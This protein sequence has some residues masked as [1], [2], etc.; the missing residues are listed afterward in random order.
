MVF[1]RRPQWL[2]QVLLALLTFLSVLQTTIAASASTPEDLT[3]LETASNKSLLWGPYRPN[4]YFGIRPR[5]PKSLLLGLM[6]ARVDEYAGVQE[7]F[8]HTCE[9]HNSIHGYGWDTYDTRRGG[10]QTI[11]DEGNGIDLK[12]K[13]VKIPNAG[14]DGGHWGVRVSGTPRPGFPSDVKTNILFYAALE[15][16]GR[17][18]PVGD[19]VEEEKGWRGDVVIEGEAGGLGSF[20]IK[21]MGD[22]M[23]SSN[24]H[25]EHGHPSGETRRLDRTFLKSFQLP[26]EALWQNLPILFAHL[27]S[28]IDKLMEEYGK[29]NLPPPEQLFVI[30]NEGGPGNMHLVQKVFE[31]AFEFDVLFSSGSAPEP[32]TSEQLTDGIKANKKEFE[33]RFKSVLKPQ[34]P[35]DKPKYQQF[36]ESL[37]SNLMGGIGYFYGDSKVDR[38]GADEYLEENEEFWTETEEARGKNEVSTEGP[39][40]LFTSIPSRPF[41]PRGFLWDEGF[42]LM[43]IIDWDTDLTLDIIKSWFSLIDDDGWIAREQILGPEARSKVP[44][45]FQVQYPHYANPPTLFITLQAFVDKLRKGSSDSSSIYLSNP[46]AATKYL[47]DLY[48]LLKRHYAWFRRT[49]AGD[50]KSYDREAFSTKEGYRWRGRTPAHILTSGLDDYPR[51]QPPHPG[52]LHVD[53]L[54]WVGTMA[55]A[56]KDI[57]SFLNEDDEVAEFAGHETAIRRNVDDL[58]WADESGIYCDAT[59]DQYD[60]SAHVCHKGYISLFPFLTGVMDL[61]DKEKVGKVLDLIG[62]DAELWSEHGIR[63][64]SRRDALYGTGENYWKSPVWVNMNYLVVVRLLDIATSPTS[65]HKTRATRLYTDLRKNLVNTVLKSWQDTGFA[66][67]QYNPETGEGQRTQHFTGWTSLVVKIMAM[68]DLSGAG[69]RDEL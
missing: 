33:N 23:G 29:D 69:V 48:P 5:I 51:A 24:N 46:E 55:I 54:S 47:R 31:G 68:P 25:P 30:E 4:L 61:A 40:E 43:P 42:H 3:A 58:H 41:F 17:L 56:L 59:V 27:K 63:S 44:A 62:D 37:L 38:S 60:E 34:A 64:L 10:E 21:V 11:H 52:E 57:A 7:N 26:A 6:W 16:L 2:I 45:E 53:A 1:P 28:S 39:T 15:G 13:F 49:Q 65:P 35:F 32:M 67:E 50:I 36:S 14:D 20:E 22:E 8:R 19:D 12:T 66:W 18:E 9:Q